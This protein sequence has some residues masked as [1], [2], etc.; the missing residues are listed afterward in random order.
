M[1]PNL[2]E[3]SRTR[4][5]INGLL[6][7]GLRCIAYVL[8]APAMLLTACEKDSSEP[9]VVPTLS[10]SPTTNTITFGA[11][12]E[13]SY[14][15]EVTTNCDT[16]SAESD[17][18][19]CKVDM[20]IEAGSFT[21]RAWPNDASTAPEAATITVS[22]GKAEPLTITATQ[23]GAEYDIYVAGFYTVEMR[24]NA[25]YWKNGARENLTYTPENERLSESTAIASYNGTVYITGHVGAEACYWEDG[26]Y[27]K[28]SEVL[29]PYGNTPQSVA[30]D[31]GTVYIL[32]SRC[33]WKDMSAVPL[34]DYDM[35]PT[36]IAVK[37]GLIYIAGWNYIG[38]AHTAHGWTNGQVEALDL[39]DTFIG[40]DASCAAISDTDVYAGGYLEKEDSQMTP[41]YWKNGV[42]TPLDP[43]QGTSGKVQAIA[44]DNGTVYAAGINFN[45]TFDWASY[46]ACIWIDGKCTV[47]ELPSDSGTVTV[48]GIAIMKGNVY[49]SGYFST[50]ESN[51]VPC[52]W[53]NE[54][55]NILANEGL[56]N[57]LTSGITL[58]KR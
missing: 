45:T 14:T 33:Y 24:S 51:S 10:I 46:S 38:Q 31:N 37:N 18:S 28:L 50:S 49:V 11:R 53:E 15:Y 27:M 7:K 13:E 54:K 58:V 16:W 39:P 41:C 22:A 55:L 40:S 42:C 1:N 5:N 34:M 20:D 57:P 36:A 32:G 2:K 29:S 9:E 12:A 30:I 56:M 17:R 8:L 52:Y 4:A 19:W 43:G 3:K 48:T 35:N 25:C 47:L 44:M 6:S 21:V 23:A 26:K